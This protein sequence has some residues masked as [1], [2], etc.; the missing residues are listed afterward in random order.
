MLWRCIA[1]S[2]KDVPLEDLLKHNVKLTSHRH[3]HRKIGYDA[4]FLGADLLQYT[5]QLSWS[6]R[7]LRVGTE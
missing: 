6:E 5:G 2:V 3:W 1:R 7:P 4:C